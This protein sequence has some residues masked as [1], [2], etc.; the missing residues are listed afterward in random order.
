LL[1]GIKCIT[2]APEKFWKQKRGLQPLFLFTLIM[3]LQEKLREIVAER[4]EDEYFVVEIAVTG[5]RVKPKIT[6]VLDGDNGIS[7]D[8]CAE[9]S[10][11]VGQVLDADNLIDSAY[12]LEVSSPGV[13][14]PL[15]LLRQYKKNIGRTVQVE[16]QEGIS[17]KGKLENVTENEIF[18][19]PEKKKKDKQ[20]P[21]L[22]EIA[23][24]DI[25]KIQVL[26][27]F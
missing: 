20:E 4:L 18:L 3:N 2:F 11:K 15:K 26:I 25:K 13:G 19:L 14:E 9:I 21:I 10:R 7:I 6:I 24:A 5:S 1:S 17:L 23:F 12:T 27:T 16:L 8:Y 22:K